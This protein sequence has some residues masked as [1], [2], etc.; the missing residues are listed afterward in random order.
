MVET[1]FQADEATISIEEFRQSVSWTGALKSFQGARLTTERDEFPAT[2]VASAHQVHIF[3][4]VR[5]V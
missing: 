4:I 1:T 2:T 5:R 3:G